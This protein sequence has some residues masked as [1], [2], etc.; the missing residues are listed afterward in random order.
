SNTPLRRRRSTA[1]ALE[2]LEDRTLFSVTAA[3]QS[4]LLDFSGPQGGKNGPLAPVGFDLALLRRQYL[5]FQANP[6]AVAPAA[7]LLPSTPSLQ[8]R[9]GRVLVEAAASGSTDALRSDLEGLG[10]Q[11]TGAYGRLVDGFLPIAALGEM[12]ALPTMRFAAPS[13]KPEHFAGAVNSQG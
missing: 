5:D 3:Y 12:A 11:V 6:P 2:C 10:M 8:V 13:Y 1:P 9:D 7:A 4:A